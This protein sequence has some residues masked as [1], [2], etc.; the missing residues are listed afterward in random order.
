KEMKD[1]KVESLKKDEQT[2]G[3]TNDFQQLKTEMNQTINDLKQQQNQQIEQLK[4]KFDINVTNLE[5]LVKRKCDEQGKQ[6]D[7]FKDKVLEKIQTTTTLVTNIQQLKIDFIQQNI[8]FKKQ[9]EQCQTKFDK[10]KEYKKTLKRKEEEEKEEVEE[11]VEEEEEVK[12]EENNI[13]KS[14]FNKNCVNMLSSIKNSS[15][16]N[17]VD[18]LLMNE[19]N[20]RI[21]LKNKEWNNYKFGIFLLGE[22]ITLTINCEIFGH[23]KIKTSHLW[24]KHSSSTIDCSGL[25]YPQNQGPGKGGIGEWC[26]G[27]GYGTKGMER[28]VSSADGKGGIIYGEEKLLKEIH[29]GSGGSGSLMNNYYGGS[30]GGIIEMEIFVVV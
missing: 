26:G 29:F 5:K 2:I 27:G 17:G 11:G 6:I 28:N 23:L 13:N 24:I 7:N 18:F 19:N 1:L 8:E 21:E 12:K 14:K 4:I 15:L 10:F 9:L 25:G 30:G 16:K 3:L 20:K 22:N